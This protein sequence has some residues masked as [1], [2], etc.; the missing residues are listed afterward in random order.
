L[1][2]AGWLGFPF[3]ADLGGAEADLTDL[4][5]VYRVAGEYVVPSSFY[6]CM[7]SGLLVDAVATDAQK[8]ELLAPMIAGE[9][10]LTTAYAE[11]TAAEEP[12]LFTTTATRS[13]DGWVLNGKK[14]FVADLG[15]ADTV[16]VLARLR[17]ISEH[18][19]WG[20]FT[21]R[22]EALGEAAHRLQAFGGTPLW[23]I[24]FDDMH[25]A[26]DALLGGVAAAS[27]TLAAFEGAVSKANA[28]QCM[29]MSGGIQGMLNFTVEY[30][31]E[32]KQFGKPLGANQAVQQMLANISIQ[33]DSVRVA[34]LKALFLVAKGRP[35]ER[36]LAIAR[37]ALG[38]SYV[39]ASITC[40]QLWGAMG[41]ARETGLFLWSERAKFTDV[42]LGTRSSHLRKLMKHM[43]LVA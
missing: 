19:G 37:V 8:R 40:Q 23:E 34:A 17:Q 15:A 25:V 28:L 18:T 41:Y 27:S 24:A 20:L 16:V 30:L 10:I 33:R 22:T 13:A 38:E 21:I 1:A 9:R 12:R 35:A 14:S 3:S 26:G 43:E 11:P 32:R 2:K 31:K 29:E 6:S 5:V 42:W 39:N 36:A 7:F 4:G